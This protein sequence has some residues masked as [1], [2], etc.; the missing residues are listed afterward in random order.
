MSKKRIRSIKLELLQKS[1]E[2]MLCAVQVYNNPAITFKAESFCVLAI[3]SWTYLCHAYYREKKIEYHYFKQ[4]GKKRLFDKTKYG[5]LKAWELERCLNENQCP[6]NN[7]TKANLRFLIGLRHEIEHQMTTKIDD[8]V[9]AKF[10]A[11]CINYE[12]VITKLFGKKYS[13]S[14]QLSMSIQF[15]SLSEPQIEMLKDLKGIPTNIAMFIDEFDKSLDEEIY[16]STNYSYR[17]FYVP[18]IA[19]NQGQADR[20]VTFIKEGSKEAD[21]IN[22]EYV[23]IK[24]REKKKLLPKQI[25]TMMNDKGFSKMNMHQ[26]VQCWKAKNARKDNTYGALVAKT[27]YWYESFI[28][29]VEQYCVDNNLR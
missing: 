19:N 11:C 29:I 5:A 17:I 27:W 28:P 1:R 16:K 25:V 22:T 26:F 23:L 8:A 20:V 24:E 15:T 2:S 12:Q 7:A 4:S 10:Q 14:N 18:K 21:K 9:S 3:I 13:V 6:F